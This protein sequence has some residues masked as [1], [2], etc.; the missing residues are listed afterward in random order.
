M[1]KVLKIAA[2]VVAIA[3]AIPT[4]GA[5]IGAAGAAA[6]AGSST[7]LASALGVSAQLASAIALGV[8][9]ASA[10]LTSRSGSG[11]GSQTAWKT[12]TK[13]DA[14][15]VFG[16]TLVGP[17][18]VYRKTN[19]KDN[20][21]QHICGILSGCGPIQ[22]IDQTYLDKRAINFSGDAVVGFPQTRVWQK[23]QLGACPESV[24][25][26]LT[27]T[28][29][30]ETVTQPEWSA[31]SKLSGY[32]AVLNIFQYDDGG[33]YKFLQLPA[34]RHL[35]KGVKCYDARLDS[36]YPGGSGACRSDDEAT[37]VFSENPWVQALTF[38]LG[39]HQGVNNIRVGGIGMPITS[40]DVASYVEAANIA[41]ANG[42]KSGGRITAGDKKW[43]ALKAFCKA[44]GGEPL[45]LG[46]T[47]SCI[48]NTPRLSVGT[49]PRDAI[50][51]D[52]NF[53]TTQTRR[54]RINGIVPV[55]RSEDHFFE[56]VPAGIVR[57]ATYL[58]EDGAERTKEVTYGMIQCEAGD[59]PVQVSQIAAY[60]I[61]NAREAGPL[62]FPLKIRWIG[63]K[64]GDC[65][66]V[67]NDPVF[68]YIAG[69]NVIVLQR[70]LD[71]NTGIV[72]LTCR[73][74][75]A[76][77]HTWALGQ[78][79]VKAPTTNDNG[80]PVASDPADATW[81]VARNV[82]SLAGVPSGTF[83]ITGTDVS[84]RSTI[85]SFV[86]SNL[87][88]FQYREYGTTDWTVSAS[89]APNSGGTIS[90]TISG[91]DISR[92]YEINVKYINGI[93]YTI[94]T[95]GFSEAA[96]STLLTS[97]NNFFKADRV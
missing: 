92:L 36:T 79:G 56:Q 33:D 46:A 69:K 32:A 42:W 24:A 52:C 39:W 38:C 11:V 96:D 27:A 17:Y 67:E 72:T 14:P 30:S 90:H 80:A 19:G 86:V 78:A 49:I 41:D 9:F 89:I 7:L 50:A 16:R 23:T 84:V 1:A 28:R 70:E 4:G 48:V 94:G 12:D 25:L 20:D 95:F 43:E 51:G 45:R 77:K 15:I 82:T 21:F 64:A 60:D 83:V 35:I 74:E 6:S 18:M 59:N 75:T 37:W 66:T 58:A 44:G 88:S 10:L 93:D 54:D 87:V 31:A 22:S 47:L 81:A 13:A 5:S 73:E 34:M 65:L 55:Y 57:N 2:I 76:S 8:N 91:L 53:T 62:V 85:Y 40:I 3:A 29:G 61:A 26:S 63:Y 97:D 71:P 68:G